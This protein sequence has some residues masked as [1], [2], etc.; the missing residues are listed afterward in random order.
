[1]RTR[2]PLSDP[3]WVRAPYQGDQG[4]GM[5][6]LAHGSEPYESGRVCTWER[7]DST[8]V[9]PSQGALPTLAQTTAAGHLKRLK[10]S[11]LID[12]GMSRAGTS[13]PIVG[14]VPLTDRGEDTIDVV[15][16]S[17][18]G[19]YSPYEVEVPLTPPVIT[20]VRELR[21]GDVL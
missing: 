5:V 21:K 18:D 7:G 12:W 4:E 17:E 13:R 19:R 16:A 20:D 10:G 14:F 15:L 11:G 1:M 3:T 8:L 6:C 9:G 2:G